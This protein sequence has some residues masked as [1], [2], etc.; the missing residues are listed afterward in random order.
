MCVRLPVLRL[1]VGGCGSAT[2]HWSRMAPQ[3]VHPERPR[4]GFCTIFS[5]QYIRSVHPISTSDQYIQSVHPISTS[6]Q[7]IR[8]VH[9]ISTSDQYIRSVHPIST[10]DQYIR[11]V[12]PR[13]PVKA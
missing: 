9:P 4:S 11:S 2:G 8:S 7:Y 10:S 6:D 3:G 5:D 1:L 13:E 12:H